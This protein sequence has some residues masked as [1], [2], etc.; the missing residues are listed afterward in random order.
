MVHASEAARMVAPACAA[1]DEALT[2]VL[3]TTKQAAALL[4]MCETSIWRMV[5]DG[6]LDSV[7]IGRSRR[8]TM[9][10]IQYVAKYGTGRRAKALAERRVT[11]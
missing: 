8:I 5:G 9:A 11:A 4:S 10:S 7:T 6:T 1:D 2:P 3:V